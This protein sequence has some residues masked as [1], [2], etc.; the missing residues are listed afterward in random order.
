M[1]TSSIG[2]YY[3]SIFTESTE[4]HICMNFHANLVI[5]LHWQCI[6][7]KVTCKYYTILNGKGFVIGIYETLMHQ[8]PIDI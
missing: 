6:V 7:T 1:V 3:G 4:K 2:F 5:S 8:S